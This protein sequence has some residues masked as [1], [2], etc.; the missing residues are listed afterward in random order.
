LSSPLRVVHAGAERD[1]LDRPPE[2]L[3]EAWF[4]LPEVASA[5]AHAGADITV[6]QAAGQDARIE[7]DGVHYRFVRVAPRD[8]VR[9][10]IGR[11]ATPLSGRWV[12][13]VRDARPDA[14]HFNGLGFPRHLAALADTLPGVP[15][16]AQDHAGG[17][18]GRWTRGLHARGIARAAGVSFTAREQA[19]QFVRAGLLPASTPV[20]EVLEQSSHF[21][22][23]DRACARAET[24]LHGDPCLL[25]LGNL[26]ANKD[27]LTA[28]GALAAVAAELPDPQLWCA[29][30]ADAL[31]PAVRDRIAGDQRLAGR[32][33]LLGAQPRERVETLLRAADFLVQCSH[34]EGSGYAVIEALACGATPLVT[35]I[36][37]FRA[38]TGDGQVGGLFAPGD[39]AA[40]GALL[41]DRAARDRAHLRASARAH[42]EKHLSFDVLGRALI[43]AYRVLVESRR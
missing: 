4:T 5:V 26:D 31:L 24:G 12:G 37:S 19:E 33:H 34:R 29:F 36:P 27:P 43:D 7:R 17:L 10:K 14:I 35:R 3:L 32:V 9:A 23:G 28:L 22:P 15:I 11:W 38:L 39:Q 30:R 8:G 6:I 42:F 21:T 20:F 2:A 41:L 13:A 16:L 40:L 25:W 1:L 18:P